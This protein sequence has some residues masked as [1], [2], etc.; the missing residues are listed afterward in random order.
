MNAYRIV[1]ADLTGFKKWGGPGR[2]NVLKYAGKDGIFAP[3]GDSVE[4]S[5]ASVAQSVEQRIRNAQVIGSIPI[6]GSTNTVASYRFLVACNKY[7]ALIKR[8]IF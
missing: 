1:P 5:R 8:H 2:F 7:A 3:H 6:A 4:S